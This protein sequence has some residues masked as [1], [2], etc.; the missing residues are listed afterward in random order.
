M[1]AH[2]R[3]RTIAFSE[4]RFT[5]A[6][7]LRVACNQW[8]GARHEMLN[9]VNRAEVVRHLLCWINGALERRPTRQ[10]RKKANSG[11]MQ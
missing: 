1:T 4:F 10:T 5:N 7:R 6:D 2:V 11:G 3:T 9:E 8:T